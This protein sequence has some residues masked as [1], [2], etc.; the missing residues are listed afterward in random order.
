[1]RL[2]FSGWR[3]WA[4]AVV[5]ALSAVLLGGCNGGGG[6][7]TTPTRPPATVIPVPGKSTP[8]PQPPVEPTSYRLLYAEFGPA[9]DIIWSISPSGPTDRAKVAAVPHK[10][11]WAIAAALSPDGKRIAYNAMPETGLNAATDGEAFVLEI[12][13]GEAKSVAKGVDLL[14]EPVWSPEGKFLFLRRNVG[15][16]VTAVLVDLPRLEED[17]AATGTPDASSLIRIVLREHVSDVLSFIPVGFDAASGTLLFIQV[18]GGT[19]SG[20]FLGQYSPA[21]FETVSTATAVVEA[22]A[23]ALAATPTL[24]PPSPPPPPSP[25]VPASPEPSP[26]LRGSHY[27]FLS[28]QT[29]FEFALSP[30]SSRLAF[31]VPSLVEGSFVFVTRV[32][33][34]GGDQVDELTASNLPAG[35]HLSPVWHPDGDKVSVGQLPA[36]G[37]PG[38]VAVVPLDG[39]EATFLPEPEVGFDEPIGWSPDG[40]FLAVRSFQGESLGNPGPPRLV[41]VS[42]EGQRPAAPQGTEFE[43]IGWLAAE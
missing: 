38:R 12:E 8:T 18:Q 17:E 22:T 42:P 43:F 35:A 19:Q 41:F 40:L 11:G 27:L 2:R 23:S 37:E 25:T 16:Y 9:E 31:L 39:G 1:M 33:D 4:I 10:M 3:L 14:T 21:T 29:A 34:I 13:T 5:A 32:A 24:P 36:G 28:D 30:D 26:A 7:E 20:T 15:D 6:G